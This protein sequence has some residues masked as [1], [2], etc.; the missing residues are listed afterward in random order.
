MRL[1]SGLAAGHPQ[2]ESR[3]EVAPWGRHAGPEPGDR[4][5]TALRTCP[6]EGKD[7]PKFLLDPGRYGFYNQ[8]PLNTAVPEP[9]SP[10]DDLRLSPKLQIPAKRRRRCGI[11]NT[12]APAR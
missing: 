4:R 10:H 3:A 5:C 1:V 11:G 6:P 2:A 12:T 7:R 8:I 9:C